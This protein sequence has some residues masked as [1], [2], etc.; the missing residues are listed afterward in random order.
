V[1]FGEQA[2]PRINVLGIGI[3]AINLPQAVA[4]IDQALRHRRKG[5]ICVTG[6][7]GVMEAQRVPELKRI[8]NESLLTTPDGMPMVWMGLLRGARHMSRV[9]GPDLM[10]DVLQMS[11]QR[12][13]K[14]FFYGGAD[15]VAEE[16]RRTIVQRFPGLQVVGSYQPPFRPLLPSEAQELQDQVAQ[17][18]PDMLWVGI[19][20]PKQ[21]RF[22]AEFLPK[23][24][25][26]L[27]A[28]VGAAFNF[29]CG[30]VRQ[31]PRWIQRSGLEWLYRC[32]REPRLWKRYGVIVPGFLIRAGLQ[33]SGLKKYELNPPPSH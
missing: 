5:Y 3:S 13:Y 14:H 15:G 28:G 21:E 25:V 26:T 7:H 29:H 16:L 19:S 17:C 11:V 20:T 22:M 24:D 23:F 27:M 32:L 33:L 6:V 8:H 9:Y 10:R 31:A 12:G 30:R 4:A 2:I 1:S 18:R